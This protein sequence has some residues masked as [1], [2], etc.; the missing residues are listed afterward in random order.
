VIEGKLKMD[1]GIVLAIVGILIGIVG[2]LIGA[3]S[4]V[5]SMLQSNDIEALQRAQRANTQAMYN[6]FWRLGTLCNRIGGGAD[7]IVQAKE[8]TT[9]MNEITIA[10]RTQLVAFSREHAAFIPIFEDAWKPIE[11]PPLERLRPLWRRLFFLSDPTTH[12]TGNPPKSSAAPN[13][14][15]RPPEQ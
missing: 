10:A 13:A 15:D 6:H 8:T 7:P 2:T 14:A 9:A 3:Y 4:G 12:A 11:I 5:R 1:V